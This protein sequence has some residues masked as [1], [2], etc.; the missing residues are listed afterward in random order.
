MFVILI[1]VSI[2]RMSRNRVGEEFIHIG[3]VRRCLLRNNVVG[4]WGN[5][6]VNLSQP[7]LLESTEVLNSKKRQKQ[8]ND[9]LL[10]VMR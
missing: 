1:N 4:F 7:Y 6:L 8:N 3:M 9:Q 10:T 5:F 2:F